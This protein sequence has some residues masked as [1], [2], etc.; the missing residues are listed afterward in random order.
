VLLD[1]AGRVLART[2]QMGTPDPAFV[3]AVRK[4]LGGA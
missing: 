2:D 1:P 4:A 3:A